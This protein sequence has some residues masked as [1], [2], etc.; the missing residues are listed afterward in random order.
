MSIQNTGFSPICGGQHIGENPLLGI[1]IEST[2]LG[3][4]FDTWIMEFR[5][6]VAEI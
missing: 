6:A 1:S 4:C 3:L 2:Q 5:P